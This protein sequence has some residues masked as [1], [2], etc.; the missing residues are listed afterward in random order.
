MNSN[1][2]RFNRKPRNS[3]LYTFSGC[4]QSAHGT[5]NLICGVGSSVGPDGRIF[6]TIVTDVTPYQ[7]VHCFVLGLSIDLLD[8]DVTSPSFSPLLPIVVTIVVVIIVVIT[9]VTMALYLM[10]LK[11]SSTTHQTGPR[12]FKTAPFRPQK[13]L[14]GFGATD[15]GGGGCLDRNRYTFLGP[16][17][18]PPLDDTTS[19]A[20]TSDQDDG[21]IQ[22]QEHIVRVIF[23][24]CRRSSNGGV[25]GG[26]PSAPLSSSRHDHKH[27]TY[28]FGDY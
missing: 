13:A 22:Q 8:A 16:H 1:T 11:K 19:P 12:G 2:N 15:K 17:A 21:R 27:V 9:C 26:H 14:T 20:Q 4:A 18:T 10:R 25:T 7:S 6:K 23:K 3:T 28:K 24:T 5:K